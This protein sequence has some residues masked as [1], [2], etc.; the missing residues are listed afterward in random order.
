MFKKKKKLKKLCITNTCTY[1][2]ISDIIKSWISSKWCS[3][4]WY[5]QNRSGRG[6][7]AVR[8]L[9]LAGSPDRWLY[10][11]CWSEEQRSVMNTDSDWERDTEEE[12][13]ISFSAALWQVVCLRNAGSH[14]HSNRSWPCSGDFSLVRYYL[15]SYTKQ[16]PNQ[17]V[18]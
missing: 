10:L 1:T 17:I 7:A 18:P 8:V 2:A 5:G 6:S 9:W 16:L 15:Q 13:Q 11:M 14:Q 12:A 3:S 4:S